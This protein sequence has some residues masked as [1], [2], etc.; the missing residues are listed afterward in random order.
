M[1]AHGGTIQ[2]IQASFEQQYVASCDDM[3]SLNIWKTDQ[4][5]IERHM[6]IFFYDSLERISWH[7]SSHNIISVSSKYNIYVIKLDNLEKEVELEERACSLSF[8]GNPTSY[9]NALPIASNDFAL[10]VDHN[11]NEIVLIAKES[12]Y[13]TVWYWDNLSHTMNT[14]KINDKSIPVSSIKVFS[15]HLNRKDYHFLITCSNQISEIKLWE[16]SIDNNDSLTSKL[17]QRIHFNKESP[18][19]EDEGILLNFDKE[20]NI[21]AV[22]FTRSEILWSLHFNTHG[23]HFYFDLA[24]PLIFESRTLIS[25]AIITDNQNYNELLDNEGFSEQKSYLFLTRKG[26]YYIP[27]DKINFK[28]FKEKLDDYDL[29]YP[30]SK[31]S[32][33]SQ[34]MESFSS[35]DKYSHQFVLDENEQVQ[36]DDILN[37]IRNFR[38]DL[39]NQL[40]NH[41]KR[42]KIDSQ[43]ALKKEMLNSVVQIRNNL[44]SIVHDSFDYIVYQSLSSFIPEMLYKINQSVSLKMNDLFQSNFKDVLISNFENQLNQSLKPAFKSS[45]TSMAKRLTENINNNVNEYKEYIRS[46]SISKI[47]GHFNSLC[48]SHMNSN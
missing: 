23:N 34:Q 4:D 25:S 29:T 31:I 33:S 8:D 12:G 37:K 17:L 45:T 22:S 11:G 21:L 19:S 48:Q 36:L 1:F 38:T 44:T 30:E 6:T 32:E 46:N 35:E 41:S 43:K 3:G 13:I 7:P 20:Y 42:L 16:L 27:F 2:D 14:L 15:Y 5:K 47:N 10:H 40:Q 28:T 39:I 9:L 24:K 26:L 18:L